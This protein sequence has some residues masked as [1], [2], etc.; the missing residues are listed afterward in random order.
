MSWTFSLKSNSCHHSMSHDFDSGL[1]WWCHILPPVMVWCRKFSHSALY[2]STGLDKLQCGLLSFPVWAYMGHIWAQTSQHSN[3]ASIIAIQ[4]STQFPSHNLLI[5]ADAL[6]ETIFSLW[7][8]SCAWLSGTRFVFHVFHVVML[9]SLLKCFT[10]RLTV[11][12][13]TVGL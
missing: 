2:S 6:V 11:L 1:W 5:H 8:D 12:S 4:L 13:S 9:L 3:V 7:C 10:Y